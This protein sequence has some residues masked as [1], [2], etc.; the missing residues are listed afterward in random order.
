MIKA[1]KRSQSSL[2]REGSEK[3]IKFFHRYR[4]DD[5]NS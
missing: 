5:K 4:G 1:F 2:I 3:R